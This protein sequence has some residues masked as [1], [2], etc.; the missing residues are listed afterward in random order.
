LRLRVRARVRVRIGV[1]R[2]MWKDFKSHATGTGIYGDIGEIYG[3]YREIQGDVDV[4]GL[5]EPRD[6][7]AQANPTPTPTPT[8]NQV[9]AAGSTGR[10]SLGNSYSTSL[11]LVLV[12]S[13]QV[14][15]WCAVS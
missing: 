1:R 14:G 7:S 3:R 12:R 2:K 8:P 11:E 6:G 5:Q 15:A 13:A 9:G 10:T 4:A